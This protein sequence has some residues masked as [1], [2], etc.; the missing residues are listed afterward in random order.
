MVET[1]D[2]FRTL[3]VACFVSLC[4]A[5]IGVGSI[6]VIAE[7]INIWV[8]YFRMEQIIATVTPVVLG[9]FCLALASAIGFVVIS[10][11]D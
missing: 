3:T 8:W 2:V 10:S 9:L 4:L 6:A 7:S 5:V 1:V 11:T